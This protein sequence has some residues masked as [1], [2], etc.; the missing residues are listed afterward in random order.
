MQCRYALSLILLL[1]LY[2]SDVLESLELGKNPGLEVDGY[3]DFRCKNSPAINHLDTTFDDSEIRDCYPAGDGEEKAHS[4]L[5][6]SLDG[7]WNRCIG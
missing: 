3:S 4:F 5:T 2:F 7:N 1:G 6:V